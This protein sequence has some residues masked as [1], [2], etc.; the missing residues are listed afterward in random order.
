MSRQA[1]TLGRLARAGFDD[2]DTAAA[3]LQALATGTGVDEERLLAA[4]AHAGDPDEALVAC[5][6][7]QERAPH[8]VAAVLEHDASAERM[9]LL[10]GASRGFADFLMRHPAEVA[11]L[12]QVPMPPLGDG[13]RTRGAA[14]GARRRRRAARRDTSRRRR[15]RS[16]CGIGGSSPGSPCTT[17]PDPT[18]SRRSTRSHRDSRTSPARPSTSRSRPPAAPPRGPRASPP[19]P[20]ATRPPRWRR[21][22]SRS[23]A[24]ARPARA[25]STT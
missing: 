16:A 10:L 2:L 14:R 7:L 1:P 12:Q 6:R 23:S 18:R 20:A 13:R 8:E 9:A 4:F 19:A 25:S 5:R 21:P 11:L 3:G 17:S 24:W 22:G 15:R